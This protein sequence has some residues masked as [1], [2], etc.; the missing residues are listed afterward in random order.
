[1]GVA[2]TTR[3]F[4][5]DEYHAMIH[6]GIL[7]ENDRVELLSGEIVEMSPI[8]SRHAGCLN[9]LIQLFI[10]LVA[11]KKVIVSPQNPI[12]LDRLSEP[13]PDLALLK[14]RD[15]P[16]S[17]R[18]PKPEDIFLLIEISESSLTMDRGFKVQ[19]YARAGIKEIWLIDLVNEVVERHIGPAE[20][21]YRRVETFEIG[22]EISP[23]AFPDFR[24]AIK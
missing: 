18:H 12:H 15:D 9:R 4:T 23:Q 21:Q 3:K 6:S 19:L 20:E 5:V 16:Y 1:M 10:E 2:I 24:L 13:Q 11:Q 7:Q 22:D 8:S 17:D 14:Y